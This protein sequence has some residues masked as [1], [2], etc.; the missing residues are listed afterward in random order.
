MNHFMSKNRWAAV[1]VT[2]FLVVALAVNIAY[3]KPTPVP[4]PKRG[5]QHQFDKT[6]VMLLA[7]LV[8]GE[9]RGE[10]YTGQMAV[11][12]VV[13]NRLQSGRFGSTIA[14]VVYETDAFSVVN[15][16]QINLTP[17]DIAVK[18]A[19]GA[20]NGKDPTRGALY[21]FNPAKTSNAWMW[22]RPVTGQIGS[23]LFMR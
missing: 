7:R 12:A 18:A 15:D 21:Y 3:A 5:S 23:H 11:A 13:V 8:Y 20:L 19:L 2:S 17:D 14:D 16:G 9:A 6:D 1:I 22:S 10:S 4:G